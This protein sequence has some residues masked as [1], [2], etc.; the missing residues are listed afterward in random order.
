MLQSN[1]IGRDLNLPRSDDNLSVSQF[2][3]ELDLVQPISPYQSPANLNFRG[4]ALD[5]VP[6]RHEAVS[7]CRE[8]LVAAAGRS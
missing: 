5:M 7:E 4:A 3:C 2:L 8:L 6:E 1:V